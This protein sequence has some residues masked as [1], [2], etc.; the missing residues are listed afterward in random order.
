MTAVLLG[1]TA[2]SFVVIHLAPGTPTEMQ[3]TLNPLANDLVRERLN[4]LYGLDRPLWEQYVDWLSRIMRLDFGIS[5]SSDA[6]PVLEKILERAPLTI[7][8]NVI[9]LFLTLLISL[10]IGIISAVRRGSL[11]DRSL[12]VLVFVGFAMPSFWRCCSC[13]ISASTWAS[14]PCRD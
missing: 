11:L 9:S 13:F 1:I 2:V 7:G 14:F 8:M 12:T 5:L 3:T 6:R 4:A 10:P